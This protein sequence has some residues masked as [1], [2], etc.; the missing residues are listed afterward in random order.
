[1][2]LKTKQHITLSERQVKDRAPRVLL[3]LPQVI[4]DLNSGQ[5]LSF[6]SSQF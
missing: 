4:I 3:Y 5:P 6:F 1:M 2:Y